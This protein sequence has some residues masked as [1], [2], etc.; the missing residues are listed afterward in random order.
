MGDKT[1]SSTSS[2]TL[3]HNDIRGKKLAPRRSPLI[4]SVPKALL[5]N[6]VAP[7]ASLKQVK[8]TRESSSQLFFFL[9]KIVALE[10]ARRVSKRRFP[11]LWKGIQGLS[12]LKF[13]PF[14]WLQKWSPFRHL[15]KG[16]QEIST[17]VFC[18]SIATAFLGSSEEQECSIE[19]QADHIPT[20]DSVA[21]E[22]IE[23]PA[24]DSNHLEALES[25]KQGHIL[26]LLKEEL[27]KQGIALPDRIN[28]DELERFYV[29]AS[30][31]VSLLMSLVK[32]TIRWREAYYFL[33]PQ[34]LDAWSNLVFWHGSDIQLRPCLVIRL[35][36][37]CSYLQ[38]DER[39]RFA[40]AV[41]SQVEYGVLNMLNSDDPRITV[42]MD[43]QGI[44][45]FKFPVQMMKSCCVLVQDHYPTRLASFYV[46]N[47]SP[48]VRVIAQAIIQVLKPVTRE[49]LHILRD[50]Y[51]S[52]LAACLESVPSFLGG[53]C[54]CSCCR[55]VCIDDGEDIV[56]NDESSLGEYNGDKDQG[57][58]YENEIFQDHSCSQML[59]AII[60]AF[61]M[62][63]ISI[64]VLAGFYEPDQGIPT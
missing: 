43:C 61:L 13:P 29:A 24:R 50:D 34:E 58:F 3:G 59:R 39:P 52:V 6:T 40:Q 54:T 63:W 5:Q 23:V 8:I 7:L 48:I 28:D 62:V 38:P 33:T 30:G 46:V 37:A 31:D 27:E 18:L 16:A 55:R 22:H 9:L 64:A 53:N 42:L 19:T 25:V 35:G 12:L 44:S 60:I 41:V 26:H 21:M 14:K 56:T 47:L 10:V 57:S 49:K 51:R 1:K 32:K 17:P 20:S 11:L 2:M 45:T 15:A 36:L 4:A